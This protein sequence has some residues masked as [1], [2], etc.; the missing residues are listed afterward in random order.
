MTSSILHHVCGTNPA[1][2]LFTGLIAQSEPTKKCS[3]CGETKPINRFDKAKTCKDGHRGSCKSCG[4]A[5]AAKKSAK[6]RAL[7][8]EKAK[9]SD[10]RYKDGNPDKLKQTRAKHYQKNAEKYR[11]ARKLFYYENKELCQS[12]S[13]R[14]VENNRQRRSEYAAARWAN[15]K[16]SLK[17]IYAK[18]E[19][20]NTD[21]RNAINRNRRARKQNAFGKPSKGI[22]NLLMSEQS[23]K[24]ACCLVDLAYAGHNLDHFVP[25]ALGGSNDDS[26]LQ[27]LC[28]SCNFSKGAKHPI[29]WMKHK[30]IFSL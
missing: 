18:W 1:K 2:G 4:A 13:K 28:P 16:E 9:E 20:E 29:D 27:L 5:S 23:G 6:W 7:H 8:P 3:K 10:S 11:D 26:N 15:N 30:G 22:I 21:K 14:W 25:L 19:A 17:V 24:C 12:M